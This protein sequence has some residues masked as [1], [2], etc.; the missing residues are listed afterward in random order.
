M[1]FCHWIEKEHILGQKTKSIWFK[2][3]Y[4]NE[5][6]TGKIKINQREHN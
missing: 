3:K 5:E 1:F 2:T 6:K 4:V